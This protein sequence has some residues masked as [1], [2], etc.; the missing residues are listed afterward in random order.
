MKLTTVLFQNVAPGTF[1]QFNGQNCVKL[2]P[3]TA[4]TAVDLD[5]GLFVAGLSNST[6]VAQDPTA[7]VQL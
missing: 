1:F 6:L 3:N 4:T 2:D 7:T 5:T